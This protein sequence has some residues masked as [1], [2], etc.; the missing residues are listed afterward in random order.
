[1]AVLLVVSCPACTDEPARDKGDVLTSAQGAGLP[2]L[3]ISDQRSNCELL[4]IYGR[5]GPGRV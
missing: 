4:A 2:M 5:R 3:E 1:M